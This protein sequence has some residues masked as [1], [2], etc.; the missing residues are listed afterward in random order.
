MARPAERIVWA[1]ETLDV[2]PDDRVLEVGCGH[3]VA[4]S[5]VCERLTSGRYTGVDRSQKMIDMATT[6]NRRYVEAGTATFE[7][8]AFEDLELGEERFD[9][10]FAVHVAAFWTRPERVLGAVHRFLAPQGKLHLFHQ[11]P[12][13]KRADREAFVATVGSVLQA[14]GLSV[15]QVLV[16][17]VKPAPTVCLQAR[18]A[19]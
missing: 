19:A 8:A 6:R 15:E 7:T 9:E 13:W 10:I 4:A 11:T 12:G 16:G 18:I 5:L 3:G 1:V 17:D 2:R 14:H